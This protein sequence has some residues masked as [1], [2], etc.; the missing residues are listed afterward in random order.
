MPKEFWQQFFLVQ[1]PGA[2][3]VWGP[4]VGPIVAML[5]FVCS[6]GNVPLAAVLWN[7]G[8]S[9]GGVIA[10]IFADLI[11]LPILNIYRK[12]YGGRMT[13]FLFVTSYVAMAAAGL[14]V[15][16]AFIPHGAGPARAGGEDHR[17]PY[18]PELHNGAE[19]RLS[20]VGRGPA[21]AV[22]P[23]E[24]HRHAAVMSEPMRESSEDRA[25][26]PAGE[27]VTDPVCGMA[28]IKTDATAS[29]GYR[30]QMF[31]FCSAECRRTFEAN[32]ERYV[33][34]TA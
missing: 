14:L 11:V 22:S 19:R 20:G 27:V 9:F 33:R 34:R 23:Y 18:L 4:I 25:R 6:I 12:Y 31:Y 1:H 24:R 13:V 29:A 21:G 32:P 3:I 17:A 7:G 2:A 8:I 16:L 30:G 10:F 28:V 15:E 26:G 5:S